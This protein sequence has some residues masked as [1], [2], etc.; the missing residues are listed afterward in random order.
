M[1]TEPQVTGTKGELVPVETI[2]TAVLPPSTLFHTSDPVIALERMSRIAR[3]LVD[4]VDDR[5]L[6]VNIRGRRHIT[7]EGWTTLAGMLGV[8][9]VVVWTKPNES[10][11]GILAR[12][13]ARTLDGRIVGAAESECSRAETKWR[14]ADAFAIRSMAQTRAIGRALRAPLGQI[15]VLAVYESA[16]AEDIH[17]SNESAVPAEFRRPR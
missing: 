15:V 4:V 5:G 10:G 6:F 11:D 8:V 1:E 16:G 13:E 7:A 17:S 9:P 14:S 2:E 3:T 12:V